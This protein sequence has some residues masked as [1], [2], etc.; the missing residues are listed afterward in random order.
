[1]VSEHLQDIIH[2]TQTAMLVVSVRDFY[3]WTAAV[4][5]WAEIV[6]RVVEQHGVIYLLRRCDIR[7]WRV[8]FRLRQ[9]DIFA[10]RQMLKGVYL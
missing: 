7:L 4:N 1:M 2:L 3:V 8:I 9:S 5:V 10:V 6:Y